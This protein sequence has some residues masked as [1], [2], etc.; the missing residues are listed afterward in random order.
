MSQTYEFFKKEFEFKGKHADMVSELWRANDYE[1]TYFKRLID[2]YILA[3]IIGFRLNRK[4]EVDYSTTSTR[5][6]FSE[7]MKKEK[8]TLD[9]IMQMILLLENVDH[10]T[11]DECINRAFKG[12]ESQEKYDKYSKLFH[13]YVRG[14]VEELYERLVV[15]KPEMD[16]ELYDDRTSNLYALMERFCL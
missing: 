7:Q 5:S 1:H 14:G 12:V 11:S 3:P 15:R 6:I 9:F 4:A 8:E 2:V 10:D 13:D 16:E